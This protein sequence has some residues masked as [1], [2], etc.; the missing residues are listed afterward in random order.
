MHHSVPK[1]LIDFCTDWLLNAQNDDGGWGHESKDGQSLLFPTCLSIIALEK[2]LPENELHT[3]RNWI[4][5]HVQELGWS[6]DGTKVSNTATA[7]AVLALVNDEE[8][9][10]YL[11]KAKD[12]LLTTNQWNIEKGNTPGTL[13]EHCSYHWIFPALM[14][15]G[16][17][18]YFSTIAQGV[19]EINTLVVSN[20]WS[21][22]GGGLTV[23]GQFWAVYAYNSLREAFDPA[24]HPYRI[25]SSIAQYTLSEP[26]FINIKVRSNWAFIIPAKLYVL[27]VYLLIC[28]SL[29]SFLGLHRVFTLEAKVLDFIVSVG[30]FLTAYILIN[31]RKRYFL[32]S[33]RSRWIFRWFTVLILLLNLTDLILGYSVVDIFNL[34]R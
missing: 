34:F 7:L 24:I 26:E 28:I 20:G 29:T 12:L 19:R 27:A 9:S 22:P 5:S 33:R 15:L 23:R 21:E 10:A 1:K 6:F 31:K 30:T 18:P 4:K 8:S 11:E 25:D 3:G 32:R 2:Y 16:I 14:K 13:W 17:D